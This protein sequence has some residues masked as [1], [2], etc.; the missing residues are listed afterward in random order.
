[1]KTNKGDCNC[2]EKKSPQNSK[3]KPKDPKFKFK[4]RERVGIRY[5]NKNYYGYVVDG[6]IYESPK[7]KRY[8][9]FGPPKKEKIYTI[10]LDNGEYEKIPEP[11]L[12]SIDK[13]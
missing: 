1:M 4:R 7:L 11:R 6:Q 3:N 2:K 9:F 12:F 13:L 5:E 8:I 10:K